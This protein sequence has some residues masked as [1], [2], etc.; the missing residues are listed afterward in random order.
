MIGVAEPCEPLRARFGGVRVGWASTPGRV[1]QKP[2]QRSVADLPTTRRV[3]PGISTSVQLRVQ[4]VVG[5]A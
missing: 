1:R 4:A 3:E 2:S 5:P